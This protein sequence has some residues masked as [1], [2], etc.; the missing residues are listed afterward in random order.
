MEGSGFKVFIGIGF[1]FEGSGFE[2]FI[3]SGLEGSGFEYFIEGFF[4]FNS[5][6]G[7]TGF[8]LLGRF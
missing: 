2:C 1:G 5:S 6:E 8:I 4:G 3:S 7:F